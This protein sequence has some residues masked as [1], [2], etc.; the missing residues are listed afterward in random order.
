[1]ALCSWDCRFFFSSSIRK[2]HM[3]YI[4]HAIGSLGFVTFQLFYF[5]TC[6]PYSGVFFIADQRGIICS[7]KNVR[8]DGPQCDSSFGNYYG[9]PKI[10]MCKSLQMGVRKLWNDE[11]LQFRSQNL[12]RITFDPFLARKLSKMAKS[13]ILPLFCQK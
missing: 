3:L 12:N 5:S 1:M 8:F 7:L 2:T 13:C 9:R 6:V 10:K 4:Y 11:R